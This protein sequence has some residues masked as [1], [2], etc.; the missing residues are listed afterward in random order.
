MALIDG[1]KAPALP[2]ATQ[3]I[4][5]G[6]AKEPAI[7]AASIIAKVTRDRLMAELDQAFP[8]YGWASN[9]GY[10]TAAHQQGMAQFGITQHH[11]RSFAPIRAFLAKAA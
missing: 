7:A 3:T 8:G 5:G 10:G 2:C 11:R 4:I 9:A 1:N 6:D